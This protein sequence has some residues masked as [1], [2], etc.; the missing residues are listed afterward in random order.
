MSQLL[1]FE[2]ASA[3]LRLIYSS[4]THFEPTWKLCDWKNLF[5]FI[6]ISLF[7]FIFCEWKKVTGNSNTSLFRV[8]KWR[9]CCCWCSGWSSCGYSASYCHTLTLRN[10]ITVV[11]VQAEAP[12]DIPPVIATPHHYLISIYRYRYRNQYTCIHNIAYGRYRYLIVSFCTGCCTLLQRVAELEP[13]FCLTQS[14][15]WQLYAVL[16]DPEW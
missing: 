11:V 3:F 1:V 2:I 15:E 10:D 4:L 5:K 16:V 8:N 6:R 14:A 9:H 7:H 12:V 13:S